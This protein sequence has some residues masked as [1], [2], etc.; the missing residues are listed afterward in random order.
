M[1]EAAAHFIIFAPCACE[2]TAFFCLRCFVSSTIGAISECVLTVVLR[3]SGLWH[4]D[5]LLETFKP[6]QMIERPHVHILMASSVEHYNGQ[7]R[8]RIREG[9]YRHVPNVPTT[10]KIIPTLAD[11]LGEIKKQSNYR[12]RVIS[13]QKTN[14][15]FPVP[16]ARDCEYGIAPLT[17]TLRRYL[18]TEIWTILPLVFLIDE[19]KIKAMSLVKA[20]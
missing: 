7:N 3:G 19:R 15:N 14:R 16:R 12:I 10:E 20:A 1:R 6:A 17:D 11:L 13:N 9:P 2:F 8:Q 5:A 18:P 4:A